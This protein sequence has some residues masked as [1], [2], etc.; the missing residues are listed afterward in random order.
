MLV[1]MN[2]NRYVHQFLQINKILKSVRKTNKQ[3]PRWIT[4]ER[5][6]FNNLT[7]H[8]SSGIALKTTVTN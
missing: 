2:N 8:K 3:K 5:L 6:F 1:K 4:Y 7:Y